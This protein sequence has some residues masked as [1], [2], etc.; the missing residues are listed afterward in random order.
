MP[1]RQYI[2]YLSG[3]MTGHPNFNVASFYSAEE[4]LTEH[5]FAVV[6]PV[7]LPLPTFPNPLTDKMEWAAYLVRDLTFLVRNRPDFVILLP[8]WDTSYGS[9]LEAEY[10]HT[11]LG[12]PVETLGAF[13]SRYTDEKKPYGFPWPKKEAPT[14][15]P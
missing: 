12:I 13:L 10:A 15:E 4:T 14:D 7:K 6:N 5:G 8:G 3:P 1:D 11:A 2:L 9:C